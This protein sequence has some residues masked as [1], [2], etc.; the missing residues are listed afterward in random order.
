VIVYFQWRLF[1]FSI[2]LVLYYY[3]SKS[4]PIGMFEKQSGGSHQFAIRK[5][6]GKLR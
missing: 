3:E 6:E 1:S 5:S 2:L 4:I